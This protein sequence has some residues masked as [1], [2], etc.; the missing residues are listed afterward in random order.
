MCARMNAR[1]EVVDL[2]RFEAGSADLE[3]VA[4]DL[5]GRRGRRDQG[6]R[7]ESRRATNS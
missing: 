4:Q 5:L 2:H 3:R 1:I 7:L 6:A